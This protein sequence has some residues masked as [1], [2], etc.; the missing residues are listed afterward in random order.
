LFEEQITFPF[1]VFTMRTLALALFVGVVDARRTRSAVTPSPAGIQAREWEVENAA[2][3]REG[4]MNHGELGVANLKMAMRDSSLMSEVAEWLRQPE[5]QGELIKMMADTNFQEQA[6]GAADKLKVDGALPNFLNLEYY[7][8]L[9]SAEDKADT[10]DTKAILSQA[11]E[12]A[13]AFNMG[14]AGRAASRTADVQMAKSKGKAKAKARAKAVQTAGPA[15]GAL[16]TLQA[17]AV[18]LN[19]IVKYWDPLK[20]ASQEFWGTSNEATIGFLRHAEIKH[21]RVAMAG[22]I[23]Y[24]FHEN[25]IHFPWKYYPQQDWSYYESLSAPAVWDALPITARAQ[26][27]AVVGFFEIF[28][29][30]QYVLEQDGQAHYMR[31]GKPGYFPTFKTIPHPVPLNLWDPFGFTTGLSEAAKAKKLKAEINNGRLAMIGLISFLAAS[32]SDQAVPVLNG[33]L[34]PYDGD[35]MA[36]FVPGLSFG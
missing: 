8:P 16:K 34:K 31:G 2:L 24:S 15:S 23:G 12:A 4:E 36:P 13:T 11:I 3:Y 7:A 27:I 6:K 14:I 19:P 25:G 29:E 32:K 30:T 5:G 26:I 20:L 28:S 35:V 18:E 33:L 22:F 9:S 1:V 17:D 21:G 10:S